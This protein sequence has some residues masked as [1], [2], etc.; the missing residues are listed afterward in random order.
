MGDGAADAAGHQALRE[1][2]EAYALG[3]LD[4]PVAT[5]VAAHLARCPRCRAIVRQYGAVIA[6]LAFAAPSAAPPPAA[7]GVLLARVA[8]LQ[9]RE[10]E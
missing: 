1:D 4:R 2:L 3:V 10:S 8:R 5:H 6:M 7:R 9:R